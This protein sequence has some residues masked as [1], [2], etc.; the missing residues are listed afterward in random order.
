MPCHCFTEFPSRR[1]YRLIQ[2]TEP[3][4]KRAI[5]DSG[6][7][8]KIAGARRRDTNRDA[9]PFGFVTSGFY[10]FRDPTHPRASSQERGRPLSGKLRSDVLAG[11]ALC[12]P[13][14]HI[15]EDHDWNLA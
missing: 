3:A 13:G 2:R 8:Q 10:L 7:H 1:I 15:G 14:G 5:A 12:D 4:F 11:C 6:N 9:H